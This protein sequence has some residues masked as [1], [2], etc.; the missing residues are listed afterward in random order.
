[1]FVRIRK[2]KIS[3][4]FFDI[5]LFVEVLLL[6]TTIETE[7]MECNLLYEEDNYVDELFEE[8]LDNGLN[9]IVNK[10]F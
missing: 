7:L 4:V 5:L 1:M 2:M 10:I 9:V 8:F 3:S 6:K